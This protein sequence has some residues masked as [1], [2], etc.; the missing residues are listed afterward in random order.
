MRLAGGLTG[1]S[2]TTCNLGIHRPPESQTT[3]GPEGVGRTLVCVS[4]TY[5][6]NAAATSLRTDV[7]M[8]IL[9][10]TIGDLILGLDMAADRIPPDDFGGADEAHG[11]INATIKFL[12][13]LRGFLHELGG[14]AR[15]TA[16]P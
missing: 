1:K 12:D 3:S 8:A 16:A 11:A 2:K 14:A 15:L 13:E 5:W 4:I 10:R 9:D 6:K 7:G